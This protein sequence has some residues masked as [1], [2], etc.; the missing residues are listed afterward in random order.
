M[1]VKSLSHA[2]PTV[3]DF[4]RAVGWYHERFRYG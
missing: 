1:R 3:P 2:G 4:G